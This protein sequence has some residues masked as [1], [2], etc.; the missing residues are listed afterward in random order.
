MIPEP[1]MHRPSDA[2]R[3]ARDLR[4]ITA[5]GI[6]FSLM[7]GAGETYL[8]AF[9]LAM[10]LGQVVAGLVSAVPLVA[11]AV[12]QLATPWAVRRLGS[13]KRWVVTCAVI[14]AAAFAP[15]VGAAL[16]GHLTVTALFA[17]VTLYWA[18]GLGTGPA[19]NT[20]VG[21][22]VPSE[23]RPRFFARRS[24]LAQGSVLLGVIAGGVALHQA[25]GQGGVLYAFAALFLAAGLSRAVSAGFLASQSEP[26]AAIAHQAVSARELLARARHGA[27]GKFLLYLLA[28]QGA[29]TVASPFFTPFM[30]GELHFSYA[31]YLVLISTSFV[32][33]MVSLP[34][35][36][37]FVERVGAQRLLYLGGIGIVPMAGLWIVN[38]SL[39]WLLA[40][41]VVSGVAWAA[42]ELATFLLL[43][44][45]IDPNERTSVLTA[46]NLANSVAT[47]VGAAAGAL[48]LGAIG[49]GR[50]SYLILFGASSVLRLASLPWLARLGR[51]E[52]VP[53]MIQARPMGVRPN[54]G[55]VDVP[56]VA[57]LGNGADPAGHREESE[58]TA[59]IA[60]PQAAASSR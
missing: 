49:V 52:V 37:H 41:Q 13:H 43:F 11:G 7:V 60:E 16:T 1:A 31:A 18:A 10:G 53:V 25:H 2:L 38:Q 57:G 14:Q 56:I 51:M 4:A 34:V 30:L 47:V 55:S 6:A 19:W 28:V 58:P 27:D 36:G 40:V 48:L 15:L 50:E 33:K 5:D 35:I 45:R 54:T 59:E 22:I 29:V 32:A 46:F 21:A 17:V 39:P 23:I 12:L 20:W 42:Y 9:A 24:R 8:P 44:E 26:P 3:L